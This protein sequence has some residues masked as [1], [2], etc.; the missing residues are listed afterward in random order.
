M[1]N[2][3]AGATLTS[4][5]AL[6]TT[7]AVIF[8]GSGLVEIDGPPT[9][10][11]N[12]YLNIVGGTLRF[13]VNDGTPT[14]GAAVAVTAANG[15]TLELAGS[16][17]ALSSAGS[18]R[19][20][21]VNNSQRTSGGMLLVSGTHQQVGSIDGTGDTVVN[22]GSDL[23]ADHIIQN[24]P[25]IGGTAG[26]PAIVTIDASD[27]SGGPLI[28]SPA[29]LLGE[30]SSSSSSGAFDMGGSSSA[31]L[32]RTA[33]TDLAVVLPANSIG[34]GNPSSVPEPSTLLLVLLA[35]TGLARQRIAL[36]PCSPQ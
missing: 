34:G 36:R 27:A 8:A 4:A 32:S 14:I 18:Y 31:G 12:S 2:V 5:G 35:I 13:N 26:S 1:V 6:T 29:S 10:G 15:A 24:A 22:E 19:V 7:G 30:L 3:R 9:L 21:I 23:T 28:A 16:V 20:N 17:A 25:V 11:D 33:G